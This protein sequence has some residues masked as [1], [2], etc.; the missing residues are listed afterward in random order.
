MMNVRTT[1]FTLM[2]ILA[3]DKKSIFE[4]ESVKSILLLTFT[5]TVGK[6]GT[7]V[8][9]AVIGSVTKQSLKKAKNCP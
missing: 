4:K 2:N 3:S 6:T 5:F 1:S 9:W 7:F 8:T